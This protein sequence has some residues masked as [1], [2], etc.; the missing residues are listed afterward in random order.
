VRIAIG[1][2]IGGTKLAGAAVDET[3]RILARKELPS[4]ARNE[5]TIV[6]G[7]AKLVDELKAIAPRAESVG[8]GCAGLIDDRAGVV[9]TSPNLP[10]KNIGI[11]DML[12]A[13]VDLPVVLENDANVAALGEAL[14]GAGKE[15]SPVLCVT[16]GT[17]IG[18]GIVIGG[19]L[20][21]GVN[22]FA[23]EVGHMVVQPEGPDCAC[24]SKGCL[25][26]MASGNAIGRMARE[27]ISEPGAEAVRSRSEGGSPVTGAMVGALAAD[28]DPFACSVVEEAGRWLG[29]GLANLA[30]LLDPEVIVVGGGAGS[31]TA[32]L[33]LPAASDALSR[34]LLGQGHRRPPGVVSAALGNDAGA[35]GAAL[36]ALGFGT[37]PG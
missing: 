31:G 37:G 26:A 13:R 15:M 12:S 8:I 19:R 22:G 32:A 36:L 11:R 1:I 34:G 4:S 20:V 17:G 30:N 33:L 21:R 3:G 35:I 9:V 29:L 16:V 6:S 5:V 25:E 2:D 10:L 24:G 27:R 18:G 23:G 7:V 14:V 28:G